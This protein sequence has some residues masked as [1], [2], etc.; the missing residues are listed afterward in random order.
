MPPRRRA[1]SSTTIVLKDDNAVEEPVAPRHLALPLDFHQRQ[2]L[3]RLC[4][5]SWAW[6]VVR[7]SDTAE[8]PFTTV[9]TGSVVHKRTDDRFGARQIG[10]P[11]GERRAEHDVRGAALAAQQHRPC[12]LHRVLTVI[13]SRAGQLPQGISRFD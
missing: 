5:N 13:L 11:A 4:S 8:S 1:D 10:R 3:M 2:E 7:N 12:A 9:R 6:S